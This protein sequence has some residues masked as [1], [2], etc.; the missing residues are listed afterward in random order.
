MI[1]AIGAFIFAG[2]VLLS[3]RDLFLRGDESTFANAHQSHETSKS[4]EPAVPRMKKNFMGPTLKFM[5]CSS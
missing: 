3:V 2:A 5:F 1:R 4:R